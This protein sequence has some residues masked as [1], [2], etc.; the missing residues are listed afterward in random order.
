M[1]KLM[2]LKSP[3]KENPLPGYG[4][5]SAFC[6]S[7]NLTELAPCTYQTVEQLLSP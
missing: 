2:A 4:E 6:V 3:V 1:L 5:L 7:G